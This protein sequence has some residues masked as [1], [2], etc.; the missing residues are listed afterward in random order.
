MARSSSLTP[1]VSVFLSKRSSTASAFIGSSKVLVVAP[2]GRP[3]LCRNTTRK[4]VTWQD[5][6]WA[7]RCWPV[8]SK[9]WYTHQPLIWHVTFFVHEVVL[10]AVRI[11]GFEGNLLHKNVPACHCEGDTDALWRVPWI[12]NTGRCFVKVLTTRQSLVGVVATDACWPWEAELVRS[13]GCEVISL[14]DA[15]QRV[16]WADSCMKRQPQQ[17]TVYIRCS[18]SSP[19]DTCM[20]NRPTAATWHFTGLSVFTGSGGQ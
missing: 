15:C 20:N 9:F 4:Q 1:S 6:L 10:D 2:G 7:Q 12:R 11:H 3:S 14:G 5:K 17:M 8:I 19:N 18:A 13:Q 16:I